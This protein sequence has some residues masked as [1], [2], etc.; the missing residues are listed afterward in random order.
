M[1]QFTVLVVEDDAGDVR[2]TR[3]ALKQ[4]K[5]KVALDVVEDGEAA[6]R[7]LRREPPYSSAKP[8]DLVILD[9]YLPKLDGFEVLRGIRADP[10]LESLHVCVVT[11]SDRPADQARARELGTNCFVTKPLDLDQ[12]Q[13]IVQCFES[14]WLT[15]VTAPPAPPAPPAP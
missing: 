15:I 4:I 1:E 5:F 10:R 2:L 9:L 6:L 7:R 13:R 8:V 14:L 3:E 11:A 12:F